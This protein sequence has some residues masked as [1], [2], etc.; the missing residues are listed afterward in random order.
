MDRFIDPLGHKVDDFIRIVTN[1]L[2][3]PQTWDIGS[4]IGFSFLI[5][6]GVF[7]LYNM[8]TDNDIKYE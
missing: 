6:L 4:T 8:K 3:D 1:D 2:Q 7:V 5:L